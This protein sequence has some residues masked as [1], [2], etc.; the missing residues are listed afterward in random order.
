V[1]H[2]GLVLVD[3]ELTVLSKFSF[4]KR[5]IPAF[6]ATDQLTDFFLSVFRLKHCAWVW[7]IKISHFHP[8]GFNSIPGMPM[9]VLYILS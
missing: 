4:L 2:A 5:S 1:S 3:K 8:P 9:Y 6:G 7:K